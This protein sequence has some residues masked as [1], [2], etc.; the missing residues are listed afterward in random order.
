MPISREAFIAADSSSNPKLLEF[1][2]K[3]SD[4]AYSHKEIE[5]LFGQAISFE[6]FDLVYHGQIECKVI[7]DEQYYMLK[8]V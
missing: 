8:S 4:K 6:L 2:T 7:Q 3:N 1:F 5:G